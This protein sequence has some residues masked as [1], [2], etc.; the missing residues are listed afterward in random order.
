[1]SYVQHVG[2]WK[3]GLAYM[4]NTFLTSEKSNVS[5]VLG[6]V[7][8]P[9]LTPDMSLRAYRMREKEGKGERKWVI[10]TNSYIQQDT[11]T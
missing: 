2:S 1:M 5:L 7:T 11:V 6:Q 9:L 8:F 4:T 3:C 10:S